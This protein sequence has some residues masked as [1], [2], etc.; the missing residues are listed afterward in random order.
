MMLILTPLCCSHLLD[1][2]LSDAL[3]ERCVHGKT[4][5]RNDLGLNQRDDGLKTRD[6]AADVILGH[7][8]D[9][10]YE[11]GLSKTRARN[12]R[13]LANHNGMRIPFQLL[14]PLLQKGDQTVAV[15]QKQIPLFFVFHQFAEIG[16]LLGTQQGVQV[17]EADLLRSRL[18]QFH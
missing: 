2:L 7:L 13:I 4:N 12:L 5:H 17:G 15:I 11:L 9:G 6:P 18:F 10:V 14:L 3:S 8:S 1:N 16:L